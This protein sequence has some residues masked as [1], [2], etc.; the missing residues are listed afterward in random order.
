MKKILT[1][2]YARYHCM[3]AHRF[4]LMHFKWIQYNELPLL[5]NTVF[6]R[7]LAFYRSFEHIYY[8]HTFMYMDR[9][10]LAHCIVY[11]DIII[12]FAKFRMDHQPV[13]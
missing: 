11:H 8:L 12:F 9:M 13:F 3:I 1:Y 4:Q 6:E 5:Q 7:Y 10:L 2:L